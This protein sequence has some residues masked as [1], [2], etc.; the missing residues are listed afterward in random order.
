MKVW[1]VTKKSN[2]KNYAL[3]ELSKVKLFEKNSIRSVFSERKFLSHLR[4]PFIINMHY[5]FQDKENL[6]IVMDFKSGGDLRYYL[7][8]KISFNEEQTSIFPIN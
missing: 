3:K 5:A 4:H 6:Y 7:A 8:K 2:N 1:K